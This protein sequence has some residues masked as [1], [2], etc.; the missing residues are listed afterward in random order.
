MPASSGNNKGQKFSYIENI[1]LQGNNDHEVYLKM[2]ERVVEG[3]H[4][5]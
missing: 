5:K 3:S 2:G 1:F 4:K